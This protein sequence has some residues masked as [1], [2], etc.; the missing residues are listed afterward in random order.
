MFNYYYFLYCFKMNICFQEE[1]IKT[2]KVLLINS[3][4]GLR[5]IYISKSAIYNINTIN[6]NLIQY[7]NMIYFPGTI[8]TTHYNTH[9]MLPGFHYYDFLN[10]KFLQGLD[11]RYNNNNCW[12]SHIFSHQREG[13]KR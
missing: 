11:R 2:K 13:N 10:K 12:V 6:N 1:N 8:L 3:A 7:C 9:L 4:C 5:K